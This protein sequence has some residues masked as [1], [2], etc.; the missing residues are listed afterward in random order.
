ML[1]SEGK[2]FEETNESR[3][4]SFLMKQYSDTESVRKE[5]KK[6]PR[7]YEKNCFTTRHLSV[8]NRRLIFYSG[9][10]SVYIYNFEF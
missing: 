8:Y 7:I 2:I 6:N 3:K 1:V 4:L 10:L 5:L 9:I